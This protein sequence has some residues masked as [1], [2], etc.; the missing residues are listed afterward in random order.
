MTYLTQLEHF[1]KMKPVFEM[2]FMKHGRIFNH[3]RLLSLFPDYL[4][5]DQF[6]INLL[7]E[8]TILPRTWNYYLALMVQIY[9]PFFIL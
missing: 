3:E 6:C 5:K 8:N 1:E 4:T 7:L 9:Y 2:M